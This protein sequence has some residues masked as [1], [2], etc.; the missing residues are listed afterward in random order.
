MDTS[1][2]GGGVEVSAKKKARA[3]GWSGGGRRAPLS[4]APRASHLGRSLTKV[5]V[6]LLLQLVGEPCTRHGPYTFYRAFRFGGAEGRI[7]GIGD[8]FFCRVW[9]GVPEVLSVGQLQLLWHDKHQQQPLA[10]LRLYFLPENTPDGRNEEHGE[11]CSNFFLIYFHSA[12][13]EAVCACRPRANIP[14]HYF[15]LANL[16]KF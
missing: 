7:V 13:A 10:S 2:S 5:C 1:S 16:C 4:D 3:V 9:E 14:P 6:L 11:V 15:S 8:F 12:S